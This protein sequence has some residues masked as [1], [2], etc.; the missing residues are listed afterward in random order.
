[1]EVIDLLVNDVHLHAN[2]PSVDY[3]DVGVDEGLDRAETE[4]AQLVYFVALG[5]CW[6]VPAGRQIPVSD[7]LLV[8]NFDVVRLTDWKGLFLRTTA[9]FKRRVL[10]ARDQYREVITPDVLGQIN[11]IYT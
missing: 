7:T 11:L 3:E 2:P 10:A 5:R 9:D 6:L 1:M 4:E 8:V